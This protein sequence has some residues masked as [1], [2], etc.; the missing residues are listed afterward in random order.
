MF[1]VDVSARVTQ[2]VAALPGLRRRGGEDDAAAPS[3][4]SLYNVWSQRRRRARGA[5]VREPTLTTPQEERCERRDLASSLWP[6]SS[7]ASCC[8]PYNAR[9]V[10]GPMVEE[11]GPAQAA[12]A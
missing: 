8:H 7:V 5:A 1:G 10:D 11:I 6:S 9:G 4:G 3:L 2:S 12:E